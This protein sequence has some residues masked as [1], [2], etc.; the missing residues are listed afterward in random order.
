MPQKT[1]T[2]SQIFTQN[3]LKRSY[4]GYANQQA[5]RFP[6]QRSPLFQQNKKN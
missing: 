5:A 2:I 3:Q 6:H 1:S 4:L